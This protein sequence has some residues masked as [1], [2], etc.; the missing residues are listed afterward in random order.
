MNLTLQAGCVAVALSVSFLPARVLHATQLPQGAAR[1]QQVEIVDQRGFEQPLVAATGLIPFGWRAEG[2]VVWDANDLCTGGYSIRWRAS[3]PDGSQSVG[4]IPAERWTM[5]NFGARLG[6]CPVAPYTTLRAYLEA[7]SLRL[8]PGAR[9]LDYRPRE[10]IRKSYLALESSTPT[11]MGGYRTWVEAGEVLIA[12]SEGGRDMRATAA[13]VAMFTHTRTDAGYGGQVMESL[14]GVTFPGFAASAPE[15]QLDMRLTEAIR[16]SLSLTPQWRARIA[17]HN[18]TTTRIAVDG[19]RKRSE[20]NRRS[21]EEISRIRQESFDSRMKSMDRGHREFIE[22]IRGTETYRDPDSSTGSVE[23]SNQYR[24][25]W[26]LN[27]GTYVLT[28]DPSFN[29]YGATGQDG[30]RLEAAR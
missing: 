1:V 25:A 14:E 7:L 23:L 21:N 2:G 10:D 4:I 19:A 5:N 22:S 12:Y 29:P 28:D 18:Q 27:D 9:V 13:A 17:Q 15:G 11:A 20:I 30:R 16:T 3:S 26:R 24:N 8:Q 6:N